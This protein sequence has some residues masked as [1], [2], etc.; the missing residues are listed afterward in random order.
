MIQAIPLGVIEYTNST[1]IPEQV[2]L[3]KDVFMNREIV[4]I[5][6]VSDTEMLVAR[7]L[8]GTNYIN[9]DNIYSAELI[10]YAEE[11]PTYADRE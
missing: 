4:W 11:R 5:S 1:P 7:C 10:G 2:I 8:G 6:G 3:L 9:L